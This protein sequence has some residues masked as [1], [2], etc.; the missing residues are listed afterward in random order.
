MVRYDH[1]HTLANQAIAY[2]S[3]K[4]GEIKTL[5]GWLL[6]EPIEEDQDNEVKSGIEVVKLEKVPTKKARFIEHNDR[7]D[8]MNVSPG[9]VVVYK[10][11]SDY[12]IEIDDKIYF[13]IRQDELMYVEEN[14]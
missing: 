6:L 9:D 13:R 3:Q 10:Q 12:E 8:W 5:G 2:K 7:T 1:G 11:G 4:T 14:N